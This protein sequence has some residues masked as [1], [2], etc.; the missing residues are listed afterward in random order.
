M[1]TSFE[2]YI[3]E[4]QS[5]DIDFNWY[6]ED[7]YYKDTIDSQLN[8]IIE[9]I[10][11]TLKKNTK[12]QLVEQIQNSLGNIS[13]IGV[14]VNFLIE[15]LSEEIKSDQ[16]KTIGHKDR[17]NL[18]NAIAFE[19]Q[20]SMVTTDINTFLSGFGVPTED[21]TIVQSKRIYV[22]NL[23][24]RIDP[25]TI[26]KIAHELK[27]VSENSGLVSVKNMQELIKSHDLKSVSDDFNRALQNIEN[28]PEQAIASSSSTLESI[29][30]AIIE[31]EGKDPPKKLRIS[32]VLNEAAKIVCFDPKNHS[33]G[34]I[35][36][37]LGG[38]QNV[39][40]GIGAL[41]SGFSSAH[42]H[43]IKKYRLSKRH[44][45]LLVNSMITFGMFL[46]ESYIEKRKQLNNI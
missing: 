28:D 3:E 45:R 41:R 27:I 14:R 22:Q 16:L 31:L 36:R 38:I 10:F 44:V 13:N 42:G 12:Y 8:S 6:F 39:I 17:I 32:S 19:L 20:S 7:K 18:I 35:K 15:F 21:V 5:I 40:L 9:K 29:C 4:L 2:K 34:E 43:G 23:L 24:K 37:I 46:I 33:E 1:K 25:S 30:R 11:W 26:I